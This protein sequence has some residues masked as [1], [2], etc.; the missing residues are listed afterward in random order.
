MDADP[1][2]LGVDLLANSEDD[3]LS[4]SA[5]VD[6]LEAI[7]S[8]PAITREILDT[9]AMRGVIDREDAIIHVTSGSF[10]R[11]QRQVVRRDGEYS[12]RRC[13]AGL[14]TGHFVE[15][16]SGD[17]GPFGPDCVR[18]ILGRD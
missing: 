18:K 14:S 7:T 6:R 8:D 17:L 15:L 3:R 5:A 4:L 9:A 1:V 11:L 16:E 10:V 13:G 12:C 2:E